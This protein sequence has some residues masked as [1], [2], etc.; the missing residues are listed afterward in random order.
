M[1]HYFDNAATTRVCT[2]A[3]SAMVE[4]MDSC[5]GNPSSTHSLGLKAEH[6]LNA[7]RESVSAALGCNAGEIYF[8]SGGTE[9]D[10]W[11][12]ISGAL[13]GSRSGKHII[14]TSIEHEAVLNSAKYLESQGFEVTLIPPESDGRISVSRLE[15]AL[16][17]DTV[18]V[19]VMLVNNETGAIHPVAEVSEAVKR[20]G[21]PA[22]IHSD[23]VQ[24]FLKLPLK[25]AE[26]GIDLMSLSGHKIHGPKGVGAL[27]IKD[28][29]KIPPLIHG[30]GQENGLRSGT[31]GLPQ[32]AGFGAAAARAMGSLETDRAHVLSLRGAAEAR[33]SCEVKG[34]TLLPGGSPYIMSFS[35]PGFRGEVLMSFLESRRVFV[36]RGSA[37]KKGRRSHVLEAMRLPAN[38][39]DGAVRVSFS[40]MNTIEDVTALCDAVR[41]AANTLV[42]R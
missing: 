6:R 32:I 21:C 38:V 19:S 41:D 20:C 31:E 3:I 33:L 39:M 13:A 23:A 4:L 1:E 30:G 28:G 35:L 25:P 40:A 37:C 42:H 22:L 27:Y 14:T 12:L 15:A 36:S 29:V 24:G 7:A 5:Y 9:A 26:L 34:F 16:R 2:E 8:T 11:A 18:L 10:N 17:P